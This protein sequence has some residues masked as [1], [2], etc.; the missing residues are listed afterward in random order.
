MKFHKK[1]ENIELFLRLFSNQRF[2]DEAM[3]WG[4]KSINQDL[5]LSNIENRLYKQNETLGSLF[6]SL[7]SIIQSLIFLIGLFFK[8]FRS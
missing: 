8:S 4:M 2:S 1:T 3:R 5:L 7:L 6:E